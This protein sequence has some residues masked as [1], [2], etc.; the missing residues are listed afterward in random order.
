MYK[1]FVFD[2]DGTLID[3]EQTG[4]LSLIETIRELMMVEMRYDEA[5]KYF[6]IPSC[7]VAPMLGYPDEQRFIDL[8][9]DNF[10]KMMYLMKPF[11]GVEEMLSAIK[12]AGRKIGCVTSRN[13]LEFGHDPHIQKLVPYFDHIVCAEDSVRH[14]PFPD[15]MY[16]YMRKSAEATGMPVLPEEC[17]YI[18]DTMHDYSCGHD[19]GCDFV[20]ADWRNRG[21]QG[22][23][24]QKRI[25]SAEEILELL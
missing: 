7:K 8:W 17:V 16:A 2:V 13:Q 9:E 20:L 4:V 1:H 24:V 21:M 10:V 14:K 15:P 5:Y 23:P 22:I 18:G 12:K 25:S 11:P 3:T 6:G 19:A